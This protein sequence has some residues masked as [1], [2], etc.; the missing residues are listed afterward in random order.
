MEYVSSILRADPPGTMR[1]CLTI[2]MTG[3][4]GNVI[5]GGFISWGTFLLGKGHDFNGRDKC[6][7]L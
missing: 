1:S 7:D 6:G 3:A 4:E 5:P 2:L